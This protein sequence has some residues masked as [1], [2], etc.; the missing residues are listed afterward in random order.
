MYQVF[1]IRAKDLFRWK[2]YNFRDDL[3]ISLQYL[4]CVTDDEHALHSK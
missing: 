3:K 1:I 4:G 2:V